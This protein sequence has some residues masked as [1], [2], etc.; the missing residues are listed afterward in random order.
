MDNSIH[1]EYSCSSSPFR[2][3]RRKVPPPVPRFNRGGSQHMLPTSNLSPNKCVFSSK[4]RLVKRNLPFFQSKNKLQVTNQHSELRLFSLL[5]YDWFHVGL[6][7]NI[8]IS[9]LGLLGTWT[10]AI[11]LFAGIYMFIDKDNLD[12]DCGLGP[13]GEPIQFAPAFAFSLETCTTVGYVSR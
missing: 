1:S 11:I 12:T 5:K 4:H 10:I 3:S 13:P 6:R 9:L 7:I 8:W 2:K